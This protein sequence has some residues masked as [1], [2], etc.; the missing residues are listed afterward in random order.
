[1]WRPRTAPDELGP[2]SA[3]CPPGLDEAVT[4]ATCVATDSLPAELGTSQELAQRQWQRKIA[5][6]DAHTV[7][8]PL[9]RLGAAIDADNMYDMYD[10]MAGCSA[11]VTINSQSGLEAAIRGKPVV[12]CGEAFYGGLGF[13]CE[14]QV[15]CNRQISAA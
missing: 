10:L 11:A 6:L 3:L 15:P 9:T 7:C 5:A 1:M 4:Y 12:V 2:T 8:A 13:T 14:A